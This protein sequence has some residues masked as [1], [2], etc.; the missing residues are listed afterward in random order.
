MPIDCIVRIAAFASASLL[1]CLAAPG[2]ARATDPAPFFDETRCFCPLIGAGI[3][4]VA[5]GTLSGDGATGLT[6]E[7][8]ESFSTPPVHPP[9]TVVAVPPSAAVTASGADVLALFAP[10]DP[11]QMAFYPVDDD[12]TVSLIGSP[13][14]VVDGA[15]LGAVCHHHL[16]IDEVAPLLVGA[17]LGAC[18]AAVSKTFDIPTARAADSGCGI[19]ATGDSAILSLS[20][21]LLALARATRRAR[22]QAR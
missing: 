16:A 8:V 19:S 15:R 21:A 20:L 3:A 2:A 6:F 17:S 12:G 14:T 4:D 1:V 5:L 13:D 9:G 7:V 22:A 11:A 10:A 18:R